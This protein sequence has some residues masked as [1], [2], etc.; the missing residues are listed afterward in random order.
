MLSVVE[1][2]LR[3]TA[4]AAEATKNWSRKMTQHIENMNNHFRIVSAIFAGS[5]GFV[6][7]RDEL[8]ERL[9]PS[10][11]CFFSFFKVRLTARRPKGGSA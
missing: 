3:T 6:K 5:P 9:S 1:S 2:S 11:R 10:S 7:A 8:M 4:S